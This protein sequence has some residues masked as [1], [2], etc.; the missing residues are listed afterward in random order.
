MNISDSVTT[1]IKPVSRVFSF[2][3]RI[4]DVHT[5]GELIVEVLDHSLLQN[6]CTSLRFLVLN[7][8]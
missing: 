8:F 2:L 3:F 1:A 5:G 7:A 6:K 4:W